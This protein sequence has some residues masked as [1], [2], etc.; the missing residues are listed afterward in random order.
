MHSHKDYIRQTIKQ[1]QR[2]LS[3]EQLAQWSLSVCQQ[4]QQH[5]KI[6]ACQ[7]LLAYAPLP[8]EVDIFP[9]I[10]HCR[11]AGKTVLLP[12]VEPRRQLSWHRYEG[13]QSLAEGA[14]RLLEPTTPAVC[15]LQ[16][17]SPQALTTGA[18]PDAEALVVLVPGLAFTP[19][20]KR[21]GR[22]GGY[23]DR[24]LSAARQS[25]TTGKGTDPSD[26]TSECAPRSAQPRSLYT[27][28]VCFPFQLID[29]LPTEPHDEKIDEI[30]TP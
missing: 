3:K 6:A 5:P 11:Q 9:L 23:Y 15:P 10:E 18:N 2:L 12:R 4:L 14:Y 27:I 7:T 30:V 21:L 24:F 29:H 8:S 13:R 17:I 20:G 22:G 1:Q 19:D 25:T 28:G 26:A 16:T